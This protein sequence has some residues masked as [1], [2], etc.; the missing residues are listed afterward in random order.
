MKRVVTKYDGELDFEIYQSFLVKNV[1]KI[2]PLKEENKDWKKYLD[3]LLIELN[4]MNLLLT[5]VNL[6]SVIGKLEGLR[7][8]EDHELFRKVIFDCIDLIK[9]ISI[10]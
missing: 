3:G 8:I 4:G 1:F 7:T 6:M 9:K 10:K 2:L 5:E